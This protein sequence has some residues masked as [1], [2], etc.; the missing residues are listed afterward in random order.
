[1]D[2]GILGYYFGLLS[3]T[4]CTVSTCSA[5][6][7]AVV[8]LNNGFDSTF[9]QASLVNCTLD[10]NNASAVG[11]GSLENGVSLTNSILKTGST[12]ANVASNGIVSHG[13][14]ISS[15]NAAG[16][17]TAAGDLP[18][19]DPF[20]VSD[21]PQDNGGPTKTI[22]IG[23]FGS[24]PAINTGDDSVAPHRDQRG[25]F[26]TG[27]SDIG[28]YEYFGGLVGLSSIARN[29]NDAVISAELVYGHSYQLERKL[30]LTDSTWQP[31][32]NE[33]AA[34]DND[35][36]SATAS[37]DISFGHAFYHIRFTN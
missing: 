17:L 9:G 37:G 33:F 36:E 27:R 26:R 28:A 35:I 4:D 32:G 12:G 14:N 16:L 2:D 8:S 34:A 25:Y 23:L 15:D 10:G 30:N 18:N 13:H 20:F 19:T 5:P 6:H 7:G 24:S 22:A 21:I 31:I 29:G 11:A 1:E 3:M